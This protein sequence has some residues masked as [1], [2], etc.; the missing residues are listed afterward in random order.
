MEEQNNITPSE[1]IPKSYRKTLKKKKEANSTA[2]T[3]NDNCLVRA[4][5]N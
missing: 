1:T 4:L 3:H 5:L 2:V